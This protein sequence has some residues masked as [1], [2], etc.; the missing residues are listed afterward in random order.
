MFR[1]ANRITIPAEGPYPD[2][3]FDHIFTGGLG[4]PRA[5]IRVYD[6][7]SDHRPVIVEFDLKLELRPHDVRCAG[8]PN[9]AGSVAAPDPSPPETTRGSPAPSGNR[10]Q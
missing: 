7:V 9:E 6:E 3:T 10:R 1:F 5:Q 2:N 8:G 4:K